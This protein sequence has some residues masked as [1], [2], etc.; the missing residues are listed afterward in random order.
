MKW[1][2]VYRPDA[3]NEL[4]AIWL[5][6]ADRQAVTDAANSIDEQLARGPSNAGESRKRNPRSVRTALSRV[7]RRQ[8][9]RPHRQHLGNYISPVISRGA[10]TSSIGGTNQANS[11]R[12]RETL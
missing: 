12:K 6:A 7:F 1:T 3:A 2:V 8:R 10:R 9:A 5:N 4:A 11:D